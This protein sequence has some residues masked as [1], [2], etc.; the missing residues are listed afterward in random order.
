MTDIKQNWSSV[1][2]KCIEELALK[3]K[4]RILESHLSREASMYNGTMYP[5]R[6]LTRRQ[7]L[8]YPYVKGEYCMPVEIPNRYRMNS[9]AYW[10]DTLPAIHTNKTP[11]DFYL[12]SYDYLHIGDKYIRN[13]HYNIQHI[14]IHGPCFHSDFMFAVYMMIDGSGITT[15]PFIL[16]TCVGP[17]KEQRERECMDVFCTTIKGLWYLQHHNK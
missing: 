9:L 11:T 1:F 4:Q 16:S 17:Y 8:E 5:S 10:G 7:H 15:G 14:R 6:R 3:N 2:N 12:E 13:S